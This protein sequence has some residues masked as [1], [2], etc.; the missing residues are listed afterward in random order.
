MTDQPSRCRHLVF[1]VFAAAL[2]VRL[3]WVAIQWMRHG[4]ALEFDDER[5]H[6]QMAVNLVER[7]DFVSSDGRH[8]ARMP[9][10]PM[11]LSLWAGLGSSS[12]LLARIAQCV[13]GAAAAAIG[14]AFVRRKIG[15]RPAVV[16]GVL[17]AVDP[18]AIFFCNLLL[19]EVLFILIA[20]GLT[21]ASWRLIN[22]ADRPGF[23]NTLG[24][25]LLGAAAIMT[26]PSSLAWIVLLW[27]LLLTLDRFRGRTLRRVGV[28]VLVFGV[29]MLPWGLR[30]RAVVGSPAWLSA[31]GGVTLYDAQGPQ[32]DGSGD[33]SFL[34]QI[35]EIRG[36]GEVERDRVL[37][38]LA[39]AQMR[40]DPARVLKL[41]WV[42]FKRT[43][44]LTPNFSEYSGGATA[45][46]SAAFTST[47][48]LLALIGVWRVF[49]V[50]PAWVLLLVLP[51]VCFT[52]LHCVFIGSLR[53]RIPL[54]PFVEMLGA[55]TVVTI[56]RPS[57]ESGMSPQK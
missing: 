20:V 24:V 57:G 31:N 12:V 50:R 43:W 7:W 15:E 21:A 4:A 41:A 32:A 18:Y 5:L 47:A 30:N 53:Y 37:Y 45:L 34:L 17:L 52:L 8:V 42:K 9:I 10:Y 6:W 36:L 28:C 38:R 1:T 14:C 48:L 44:S 29:L 13:I 39:L 55:A 40:S 51:V 3:L 56:A 46:V 16:A 26:R 33:Q 19:T 54:M 27:V 35:E 25:A 2:L 22:N 49:R 11:F 23:A